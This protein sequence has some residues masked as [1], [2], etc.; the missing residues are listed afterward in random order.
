MIQ[1]DFL[2]VANRENLDDCLW[3]GAVVDAIPD[4]LIKAV[5]EFNDGNHRY[6]WLKYLPDESDNHASPFEDVAEEIFR[7]LRDEEVL[8]SH[9]GYLEEPGNLTFVPAEFRDEDGAPL[10]PPAKSLELLSHKYPTSFEKNL[11]RMGVKTMSKTG[12]LRQLDLLISRKPTDLHKRPQEWHS[13]LAKVLLKLCV[14]GDYIDTIKEMP[15]IP[16]KSG[17]WVTANAGHT[18][19]QDNSLSSAED[20]AVLA[21]EMEVHPA[22]LESPERMKLFRLLGLH[23]TT[24]QGVTKY[25]IKTQS[26]ANCDLETLASEAQKLTMKTDLSRIQDLLVHISLRIQ[27]AQKSGQDIPPFE[28]YAMFPVRAANS[29][30]EFSY[31]RTAR[32]SEEWFIA[33]RPRPGF[34]ETVDLLAISHDTLNT[35]EPL[36]H[37]LGLVKRM[38]DQHI[39]STHRIVGRTMF[40]PTVTDTLRMKARYIGL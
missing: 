5:H 38:L 28:G 36:I 15:I 22:A 8:E 37:R 16:L 1:G 32:G 31:L 20:R 30:K 35:L 39:Q 21:E 23:G 3:N 25:A 40:M 24:E 13:T 19:L 26:Y 27:D 11:K 18:S 9:T 12:F 33:D 2:L 10:V 17:S 4:A 7:R 14:D 29:R 6:D 34:D